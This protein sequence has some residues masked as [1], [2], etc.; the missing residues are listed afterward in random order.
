[1]EFKHNPVLLQECIENLNI[2]ADGI[3][4]DGTLGGAG[5]SIEYY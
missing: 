4:V 2:K 5:H 3:Y 1:M